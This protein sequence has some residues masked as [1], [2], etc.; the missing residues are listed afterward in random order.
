MIR[1]LTN[2]D[3]ERSSALFT[4]MFRA[5]AE[6]F[7]KRLGWHVTV[8][9]GLEYDDYDDFSETVYIISVEPGG[10]VLGSLR[11]LPTTGPTMLRNEFADFFDRPVDFE[12]AT[13]WECTRFCVHPGGTPLGTRKVSTELLAALCKTALDSGVEHIV[14]LYEDT[15]ERVYRRIGWTPVPI[16]RAKPEIGAITLGLWEVN[17]KVQNQLDRKLIGQ[18]EVPFIAGP[19]MAADPFDEMLAEVA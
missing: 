8:R 15:M 3:K 4:Q 17:E 12:S 5:R 10:K 6:V 19:S 13:A 9:N 11:L 16:A 7:H 18:S 14:G 1:I 2:S